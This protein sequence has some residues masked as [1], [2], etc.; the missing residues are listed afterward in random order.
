MADRRP[1]LGRLR[2]GLRHAFAVEGRA[3][4]IPTEEEREV[5]ER[6]L[7]AVVRRGM[8]RPAILLLD[9]MRP[10]N[11][12][13][14][15]ALHF[16]TPIASLAVDAD[17][18]RTLARYLERRGSVEWICGRLEAMDDGE[19]PPPADDRSARL[20]DPERADL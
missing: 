16:F 7:G 10:M 14:A 1:I 20:D 6:V 18:L 12:V 11:A 17:A 13:S 5:L 15:Q 19:A 9:S 3:A 2:D 4:A 8:A